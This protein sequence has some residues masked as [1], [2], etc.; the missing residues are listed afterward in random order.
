MCKPYFNYSHVLILQLFAYHFANP[1][2][3]LV[4][5]LRLFFKLVL[6]QL[7]ESILKCNQQMEINLKGKHIILIIKIR[8]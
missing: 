1:P 4:I 3:A 8:D 6:I 2:I 7:G 5:Y